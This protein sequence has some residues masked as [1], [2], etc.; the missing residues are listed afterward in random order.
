MGTAAFGDDPVSA[1]GQPTYADTILTNARIYTADDAHPAADAVAIT[2]NRIVGVS[3][4]QPQT[5][6]G[7]VGP[8]TAV[9][10]VGGRSVIPGLVDS[11]THPGS[12]ALSSWHVALPWSYELNTILSFL[13]HYAAEHP[14]SEVPFIY[15]E[16]YPSDMD[17]GPEGPTAAAI[18][19][20]VLDRPVLLQDFSDH[21]STVNSKMLELLGVNPST[22]LQLDPD[23]PA[24]Q[25]VRGPDGVTPT[26]PLLETAWNKFADRMYTAI[27]W[28]PPSKV[29][30]ELLHT[31][32]SFL[33]AKGVVALL[34]AAAQE[35]YLAAAAAL[36][37]QGKLNLHYH[38][39]KRFSSLADL[40]ENISTVQQWQKTYG[41]THVKI[42]GMKLFLDGTNEVG[43]SAVLEPFAVGENNYGV[44]R[45]SEDHL[46]EAMV[47]LNAEHL[48]LHIHVVG[49]RGFRTAL[50]AVERAQHR[51]GDAW[52]MQITLAH[53][54]LIDPA[55]MPRVAE[56]GV[57][58][59]W[60]TH[61]SGGYFTTK[62]ASWLGWERF[63]RMYQFNPIIDSGGVVNYGSDVTTQYEAARANPFLGMQIAHTRIDPQYSTPSGPGAKARAPESACLSLENLLI[64]YTRNG[65]RQLRLADKMGSIEVGKLANLVVLNANLFDV[66]TDEIQNVTPDAVLFEGKVVYGGEPFTTSE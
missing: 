43:T 33:S 39:V 16:Y 21:A 25:F 35:D 4:G 45:V 47:L 30:P 2:G 5:W 14:V 58:L 38:A 64:G 34:D 57:I 24:P 9:V 48:D 60:T 52:R 41:G 55:D 1:A 17:W 44:L 15:A 36:D 7:L 61:W 42:D 28:S 49:D 32:I 63:N 12:V 65:A 54:E 31:F 26:G 23:D 11:H 29:T 59:N 3:H 37:N 13:R 22:P 40:P 20:Y 62:S 8:Q 53:N 6:R 51:L 10:D 27:G 56:L 50:N 46:I 19:A 18:D 66:A